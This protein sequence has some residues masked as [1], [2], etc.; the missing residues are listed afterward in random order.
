MLPQ[1]G[2]YESRAPGHQAIVRSLRVENGR[3]TNAWVW[4]VE[5]DYREAAF[6]AESVGRRVSVDDLK[7]EGYSYRMSLAEADN[8]KPVPVPD[9]EDN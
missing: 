8:D 2:I 4:Q 9:E 5:G 1:D 6:A 7:A 3:V